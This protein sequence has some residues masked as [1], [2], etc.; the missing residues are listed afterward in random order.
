MS[1]HP[2]F[3]VTPEQY[4]AL[5]RK[6]EGKSEYYDGE[7][8]LMTGASRRHNLIVLN[9]GSELRAQLKSRQC[10]V[11]PSDMRVRIPNH[12]RYV[13]PDISVVCATPNFEDDQDDILLNPTVV[14]EVLSASTEA[15]DRGRKF[16]DYRRIPS[17]QEYLLIAQDE[18]RALLNSRRLDGQWLLSEASQPDD[19]I[20]LVSISCRLSF[21]EIYSKVNVDQPSPDN[22]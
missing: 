2:K 12:T 4:L 18:R 3:R 11:Y 7:L 22:E 13:Y 16:D 14:I 19:I 6:A 21:T 15:Y 8:F 1:S 17:L 10:E 20:D 9:V 5:D